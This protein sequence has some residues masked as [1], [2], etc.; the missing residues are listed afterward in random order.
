MM[1]GWVMTFS[2]IKILNFG[3]I[4]LP[5]FLLQIFKEKLSVLPH[6]LF[7]DNH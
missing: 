2:A 4:L 5:V 1:L 3:D 6:G 7:Y